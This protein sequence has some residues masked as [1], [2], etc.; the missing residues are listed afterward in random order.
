M[1]ILD[2]EFPDQIPQMMI[3]KAPY[4]LTVKKDAEL[5]TQLSALLEA[6][7]IRPSQSPYAAPVLFVHKK[8][9]SMR[10]CIDYRALNKIATKDRFPLPYIHEDE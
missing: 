4:R 9:G 5:R 3:F 8:D 10:M 7:H 2:D 6:G 1:I